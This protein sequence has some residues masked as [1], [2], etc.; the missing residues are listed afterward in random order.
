MLDLLSQLEPFALVTLIAL[1]VGLGLVALVIVA[2]FT[3]RMMAQAPPGNARTIGTAFICIAAASG[4]IALT[5]YGITAGLA[6][7][8]GVGMT[9][10][11]RSPSETS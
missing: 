2:L 11:W 4:V 3:A 8:L 1:V 10:F 7:V 9:V 5:G 6:L